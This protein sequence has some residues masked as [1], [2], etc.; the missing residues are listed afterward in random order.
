MA[1]WIIAMARLIARPL[2]PPA[3]TAVTPVSFQSVITSARAAGDT[4]D[5]TSTSRAA[6]RHVARR[7]FC[8]MTSPRWPSGQGGGRIF[9][10]YEGVVNTTGPS[11]YCY[12]KMSWGNCSVKMSSLHGDF[13]DEPE[14]V[15]S[16][17]IGSGGA[18]R[19]D[20]QPG[21]GG[22]APDDPA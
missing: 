14:G 22:R 19:A 13:H 9:C 16:R 2:R 18:G 21:G 20:Q 10:K 11:C 1:A 6:T 17:R 5:S 8:I 12:I 4:A 15:A 7:R 3:T